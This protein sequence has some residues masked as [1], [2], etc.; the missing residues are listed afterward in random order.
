MDHLSTEELA[1]ISAAVE[2]L[3]SDLGD[4]VRIGLFGS[5]ARRDH[6]DESDYDLLC[7]VPDGLDVDWNQVDE[8]ACRAMAHAGGEA[9]IQ[10][11]AASRVEDLYFDL[12]FL[13][14]AIRDLVDVT[15]TDIPIFL[16]P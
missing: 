6:R 8:K 3:K 11:V 5:R 4:G 15:R 12:A 9:N 14:S 1:A 13:P 2:S 10:F 7:L 16:H